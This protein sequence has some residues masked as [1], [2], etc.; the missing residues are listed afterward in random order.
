MQDHVLIYLNGQRVEVVRDDIFVPMAEFLRERRGLVGT[1][2]GCGEGDC[3]ACTVLIGRPQGGSLR[4]RTVSSCLQSMYQLDGA[5][6]VTIEGLTPCGEL[7]PIQQAMVEHHGSQC[8][9]C[10]PGMVVALEGTFDSEGGIDLAAIRRGL[11]GKSLPLHR[12]SADTRG[13]AGGGSRRSDAARQPISIARDGCTAGRTHV[14][15]APD[16]T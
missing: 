4:Y 1:K 7:S 11:T 6:V 15:S 12:V 16:R 14:R 5:H 13:R 10:T 9:Y 3:G 8:G 2:V